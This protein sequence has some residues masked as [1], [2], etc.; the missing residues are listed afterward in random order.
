MNP[1]EPTELSAYLDGEL[2]S[3]RMLEIE[4]ALER[5][6]ELRAEFEA[7]KSAHISWQAAARS[8]MFTPQITLSRGTPFLQSR[9]AVACAL[10]ILLVLRF[11]P[12]FTDIVVFAVFLHAIALLAILPWVVQMVRQDARDH[13]L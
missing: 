8:A 12:K 4:S 3:A 13:Y 11:V 7:L 1:I 6:A 5:D 10:V 2:S 9:P